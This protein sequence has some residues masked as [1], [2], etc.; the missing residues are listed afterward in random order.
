MGGAG[1]GGGSVRIGVCEGGVCCSNTE[2]PAAKTAAKTA[3]AE[4]GR[5]M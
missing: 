2:K 1:D 5:F 3:A 4:A